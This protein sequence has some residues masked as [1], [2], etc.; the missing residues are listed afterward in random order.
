ME[1]Y[2]INHVMNK[3]CICVSGCRGPLYRQTLDRQ[4]C[5]IHIVQ[6]LREGSK[7]YYSLASH[8]SWYEWH[9]FQKP[10]RALMEATLPK[11][12]VFTHS[13]KI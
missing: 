10:F 3:G 6:L 13:R 2:Y 4:A 5:Q 8:G 1:G 7:T 9:F 11:S 12:W